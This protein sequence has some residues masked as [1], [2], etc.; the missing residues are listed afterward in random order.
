MTIETIDLFARPADADGK[1]QHLAATAR[2]IA[3]IIAGGEP[4]TRRKLS[5][6]LTERFGASDA[7]GAWSM[8]DA[9]DALEAAQA[10]AFGRHDRLALDHAGAL[11]EL[12]DL[13][14]TINGLPTQTYRTEEQ[15]ARQQ[16]S[17]PITLAYLVARA[18]SARRTD[19]VLEPSA[20]TGLLAS[21]LR[22]QGCA[23]HLNEIDEK[24]ATML[25][26]L[27]GGAVTRHDA[28]HIHEVL[29]PGV[30][31]SVILMNPPFSKS[32]TRG[33]DAH[34]GARHLRA[35]LLRL[36]DH[37]RC[38]SIMPEW[39]SP[40]RSGRK[41]Y[42][43][44]ASVVPPR[45][46]MKIAGAAYAK[47]GTGIDVRILIYDKG[48]SGPT[49]RIVAEDL[50]AALAIIDRHP[51]TLTA[52]V[53]ASMLVRTPMLP[54]KRAQGGLLR[55]TSAP[56]ALAPKA[57]VVVDD[58]ATPLE[59]EVL[60]TPRPA[61]EPVGIYVPY[62][63]ARITIAGAQPHPDA[64]V[65]S[66]AMASIVPPRPD[67]RPML[68]PSTKAGLSDAQLETVIYAGQA[69]EHDLPGTF[70]PNKAGTLLEA[71]DT[72]HR[73]RQGYFLG[74]G[75]GAG[76]G[77]QV[78]AIIM[79]QWSQGRRKALWVSKTTTLL[80]DA[81][82]DWTAI[83]G[84]SI[85]IQPLDGFPL[86]TEI[87]MGSGIL[88][89]T[90]ATLRSQRH[91]Q[92]SR[93]QQ[94]LRWLGDDHDGMLVF[95][96]AH[97]M[98]NAA[99]TETK[100]GTQKGSEQGL[101]GV[102]LQNYLPRARVLYVSATGATVIANLCYANR[103]PLWGL[104]TAFPDREQFMSE[105]TEGGIAAM[106]LVARDL[107]AQGLYTSR[108][109]SFAG[110]EYE[111]LEHQLQP[112]Q[113]GIYDAYADAW[114]IIHANLQVALQETNVVDG[115]E[116]K[117]L[118]SQAKSSALSRFE[119]TKQ[120]FFG[121]MLISMKVRT[122]IEEI[123]KELAKGHA[124]VVQ[125]VTTAEAM[126][127]RRL[128]DLSAEDRA[129]L[130]IELS[131]REYAIDYLLNAFPTRM[132][133]VFVDAEGHD[134]SEPLVDD[135]GRPVHSPTALAARDALVE[136]LC[137]MPIVG[138]ALDEIIRHFGTKTVAEVTGR[139]KRL[140]W[141][142]RGAQQLESRSG[143]SNLGE[144]SA[145]MDGS[146]RILIF[147]DAGGTGRSYHADRRSRSAEQRRIHFLLEPGWKA[148]EAIQ[149]LGRT[150][151]TNQVTA[152]VF[153]PCTTNCRGERRFIST[154]ARRL[155][156]LGALTRGQRQT[157]GQN[158]FDPADNLESDYA[159]EAL[160][161]WYHLLHAGV[162]Q[163][164]TFA[165]FCRMTALK[166][167]GEGGGLLE[168]LPPIQRWLNRILALRISVQDAIFDEYLGL[169]EKRVDAAR[170][171]GTLDVGVETIVAETMI[172]LAEHTLRIDPYSGAETKLLSLELHRKKRVTSFA[173]LSATYH[174][175]YPNEPM[176]NGRS[177][178][179][180]LRVPSYSYPDPDGTI[181]RTYEMVRP[182]GEQRIAEP[183]LAESHWSPIGAAAFEDAWNAEVADVADTL[184]VETIHLAT[185][186]LLPVW[187]KL[188][189][190]SMR[191]WRVT[192]SAGTTLLGRIIPAQAVEQL[193]EDMGVGVKIEIPIGDIVAAAK[194]RSGIAPSALEGAKLMLS[195]VNGQQRVEV[196]DFPSHRL[197]LW[198]SM[199]CFTE[200]QAFK[201]RLYVPT[202]RVAEIVEAML[203]NAAQSGPPV[204]VAA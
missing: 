98:A 36:A 21:W 107:K 37:G 204:A 165:D 171:A 139:T 128:A 32:E 127:T 70:L 101:T 29:D 159:K 40:T 26:E 30:R 18:A 175:D 160:N 25:A 141:N 69:F 73:Y 158:L 16:F 148:A 100:F 172:P 130:D 12:Q 200:I 114:E 191:V 91:D 83:G 152:P 168:E 39:F 145:F 196:R 93:L 50:A 119:S 195:L 181:I 47:H 4:I 189:R 78:A 134:R 46:D 176:K 188:P 151:R 110:V 58:T 150:H 131:P 75:T 15:I 33:D 198:K 35:A 96:E 41:G 166:L 193:A 65:E 62:R 192:D 178:R 146:K 10:L 199:G 123:E 72:G 19:V 187:N 126:L 59:Y 45:L 97:A 31:P 20:G 24:R 81:R 163:S 156:S 177:G 104:G 186:L 7:T 132:M 74:D 1:P 203:A 57:M 102:R 77:R 124:A 182:T 153:R 185:G 86:G 116:D 136:T 117:T 68:P 143:R 94:I 113:V 138:S 118:N 92:A 154:I 11:A 44:V 63:I 60:D 155:D 111:M 108:A 55:S 179:V 80:E 129:N 76:K 23:L 52:P 125:L 121:Q 14:A 180:A 22:N 43:A 84:T 137:A 53:T 64:L 9:Y 71:A 42:D 103:L 120:R 122:I 38:V 115:I 133:R 54:V 135:D 161:Q 87:T 27:F 51:R 106:E 99:G 170:E 82:R 56:R 85:D 105:M 2:T 109:L 183:A 66:T 169:I 6:M 8:R 197:A 157:G 28:E 190:G 48:Y 194:T 13:V 90:Y 173:R 95:D 79:D 67:Y 201:T 167:E 5:T 49:E 164:V 144:T 140:T 162:L 61:E 147:S 202:D 174:L 112:D 89:V 3:P 142:E 17:T 88:F 149:G 34:A 184:D